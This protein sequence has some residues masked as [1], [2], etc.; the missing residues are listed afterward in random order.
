MSKKS[1]LLVED[2]LGLIDISDMFPKKVATRAPFRGELFENISDELGNPIMKKIGDNTVV[3]GGAISAL[4]KL[5]GI[6]AAWKPSTLN[7]I[8]NLNTSVASDDQKTIVALWGVGTGGAGL[9]FNSVVAKDI[10]ARN[11]PTLIPLR[12]GTTID[13]TDASKYYMKAPNGDGTYNWY[14]KEFAQTPTIRSFWKDAVD[15]DTDGTEILEDIYN[16][17]RTEGIKSFCEYTLAF[18]TSDVREYF[19]ATGELSLARYNSIGLFLGEKVEIT[20]GVFDY[21][22]VRLFAYLNFDN[23]DVKTKTT[24][25]YTYRVL[26]LT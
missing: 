12:R 26:A 15:D 17:S 23:K 6:S 19:E 4:E 10:K 8:L 9:E 25:S 13:G 20:P 14:L 1:E 5:N 2:S 16:S 21:V 22:N 24:A 18:N 7:S 11:L 3:V